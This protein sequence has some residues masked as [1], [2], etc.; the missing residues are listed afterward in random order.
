MKNSFW[1]EQKVFVTGATGLLGSWLVK[2]LIASGA[3]ITILARD[4]S[5][6]SELMQSGDYKHTNIIQGCLE[7]YWDIERTISESECSIVIHLGAQALVSV[8]KRSP[9]LTF[10]SN[11]RGTYNLLEAARAH[12][13][14]IKSIV[15]ASSDKAYGATNDLPYLEDM[16]LAGSE[17]YEVSKSCTDLISQSYFKSYGLPVAIARCGNIYG[18]GDLNFNRIIPGTIKSFIQGKPPII[19]SDGTFI[20]DYIYVK[21]TVN[22]YLTLAQAAYEKQFWGEAFN[23]SPERAVTVLELVAVL[24]EQ[25]KSTH[26]KPIIENN[27]TGEIHSQYLDSSKAHKDLGWKPIYS[28]EKGLMETIT[29]Y[30]NFFSRHSEFIEAKCK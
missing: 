23:F 14:F 18:G 25:M 9:L 20:R 30:R 8:G 15:V 21:D 5:P 6:K 17:P 1:C 22:A 10:E 28:L 27:A 2:E 19:R 16:K 3:E 29:W 7:S 11:I 26:L 12:S 13:S 4:L 24:Q